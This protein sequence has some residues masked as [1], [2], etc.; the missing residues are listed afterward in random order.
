MASI[1]GMKRSSV[2]DISTSSK[3]QRRYD[4]S[5]E[6]RLTTHLIIVN[7][8]PHGSNQNN[9]PLEAKSL[10]QPAPTQKSHVSTSNP[11][12]R[13]TSIRLP[14]TSNVRNCTAC[15]NG[16]SGHINHIMNSRL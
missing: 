11:G 13:D 10:V 1:C 5:E 15:C 4:S 9:A 14:P 6:C 3:R 16:A 12:T 8:P 7:S 2:T